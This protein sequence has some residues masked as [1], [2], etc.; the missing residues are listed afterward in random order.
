MKYTIDPLRNPLVV[1]AIR[2]VYT[3]KVKCVTSGYKT[4]R[5]QLVTKQLV[6]KCV[7]DKLITQA[8][9]GRACGLYRGGKNGTN[10]YDYYRN[11]IKD[12]KS[13]ALRLENSCSIRRV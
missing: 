11:W 12:Y 10:S 6:A 3:D 1:T 9:M 13:G 2:M 4:T 7:V 8:A 5:Y